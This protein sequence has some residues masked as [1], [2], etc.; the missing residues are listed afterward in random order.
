MDAELYQEVSNKVYETLSGKGLLPKNKRCYTMAQILLHTYNFK[1]HELVNELT[2]YIYDNNLMD[3]YKE[4]SSLGWFVAGICF[5]LL[6]NKI[7]I[8]RIRKKTLED[9]IEKIDA[10][11]YD[12]YPE[13]ENPEE[14]YLRRERLEIIL[15]NTNEKEYD[16]LMDILSL[17]EFAELEKITYMHAAMRKKRLKIRLKECLSKHGYDDF[18]L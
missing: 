16:L 14:A 12:F 5:N 7:K 2:L 17:K 1:Q 6:R 4:G 3:K 11:I 9:I 13:T 8:E 18:E 10:G 15:R